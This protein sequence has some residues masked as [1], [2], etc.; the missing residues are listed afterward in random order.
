ML[1]SFADFCDPFLFFSLRAGFGCLLVVGFDLLDVD[2]AVFGGL[3][4][5]AATGT[6]SSPEDSMFL[7]GYMK[8]DMKKWAIIYRENI[9]RIISSR[10]KQSHNVF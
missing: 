1:A 3:R 2:G 5:L 9:Q 10:R 4:F 6:S 7:G 8:L